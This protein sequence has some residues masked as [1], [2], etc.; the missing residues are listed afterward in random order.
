MLSGAINT[1]INALFALNSLANTSNQTN[2]LEQQLSSGLAINS[3][4]DNPAGYIAAQGFTTQLGGVEQAISNTNQ[5]ISLVQT[6]DGAIT[7]QINILQ[8]IR[9]IADQAAN[10]I[11]S[12]QQLQSLQQ[13]VSQLQTQ[14]TTISQQTQFSGLNLIDGTFQG[15][16]FQ[17]GANAGQIIQ[18]S[19]GNTNANSLGV[20]ASAPVSGSGIYATDGVATGGA[21][22]N[23]G[24]SYVISSGGAGAFTSGSI[25]V[26]GSAGAASITVGASDSA[27][28]IAN[29]VNSN[30]SATNV[31]ATADT[32]VAFTVGSGS[33]SFTLGN[34]TGA[35]QTNTVNISASVTADTPAGLA[36]LVNAVNQQTGATGITAT[37]NASNQLVLTQAQGDNISI[38]GFA[39]TGT[40]A[41]GGS[42]TTT[43]GSGSGDVTSATIQGVVTLDSNN[44]FALSSGASNIGLGT[45]S[46]LSALSGVDVSTQS[47]SNAAL[48]VVDYAIQQLENIGGQLGAVQQRLQATVANLQSTD[49][50]LTTAQGVVQ[51]ANIPQVT[52]QLTQQEILQQA[53][54]SAL[55]QSSTLQQSFLKLLQ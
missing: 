4:A 30:E 24:A 33:V 50:N 31:V 19:I 28:A 53:G 32:S 49:T 41:A 22:D 18:L 10:G 3:P 35:A 15:V 9:T 51:D 25:A 6:A 29:S 20:Y 39:G 7:Q 5:A 26:S 13:V 12:A 37:V 46:S 21:A 27:L 52:T 38:S 44:T 34:G 11:N 55:S 14:V 43:I 8:Q 16:Q 45:S 2:T 1:N 17:V 54:V 40:L 48:T 42:T 23:T 36:S 47:G